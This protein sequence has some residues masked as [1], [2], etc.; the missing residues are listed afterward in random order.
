[1][2]EAMARSAVFL[3]DGIYSVKGMG[4][5]VVNNTLIGTR[6]IGGPLG[7]LI[8]YTK[9]WKEMGLGLEEK[10]HVFE[11]DTSNIEFLLPKEFWYD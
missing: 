11:G 10:R 7:N 6:R 1:M 9:R 8:L 2:G 4:Y 5:S 3:R